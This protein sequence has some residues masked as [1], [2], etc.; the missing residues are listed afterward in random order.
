VRFLYT[1]A[2]AG[3][4]LEEQHRTHRTFASMNEREVAEI[5]QRHGWSVGLSPL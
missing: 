2:E 5:C 4:L 3:G 1:P